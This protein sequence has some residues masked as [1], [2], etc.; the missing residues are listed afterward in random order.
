MPVRPTPERA[1]PL[2]GQ[3]QEIDIVDRVLAVAIDEIDQAAADPLDRRDVQL[4]RA[5]LA[6]HRLG[7]EPDRPVIGRRGVLD[8]ERDRADRRPVQPRKGLREALRFGVQDEIDVA[9]L[10][11]RDVFRAV[12]RRRDKPHP[13][14][15]RRQFGGLGSGVFDKL[16]PVGAHR[17]VPQVAGHIASCSAG[18]APLRTRPDAVSDAARTRFRGENL[19]ARAGTSFARRLA[20][21]RPREPDIAKFAALRDRL[22]PAR[23]RGHRLTREL[24]DLLRC[25]EQ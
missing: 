10:I 16:E 18:W 5:D 21:A 4:H 20:R 15:Q 6:V 2:L 17:V 22:D 24:A 13:L 7:A 19:P 1:P 8:A 14:E 9:L 23:T 12:P 3:R 11:E 25:S